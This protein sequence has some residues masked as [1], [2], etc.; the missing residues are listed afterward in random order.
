MAWLSADAVFDPDKLGQLVVGIAAE[1]GHHDSGR[2]QHAMGQLL[3]TQRGCIS[4]T[5]QDRL[6]MLPPG[7]VAWIPPSTPH[8]AEMNE[9][10]GYRSVYLDVLQLG[11]LPAETAVLQ[12]NPLLHAVLE[13]IATAD[14][15]TEWQRGS[16]ANLLAVCLDE[17]RLAHRE[18][19]L[20]RL[21][22]D[23]RLVRLS[24]HVLPASLAALARDVGASEKT[25]SR[26][27]KRQ[28]GLS[29]QQWRQQ[30]RFLKAVE[31][32][33]TKGRLSSVATDLGFASDS[34]FIAFFKQ[35]S[36]LTPREYMPTSAF[37]A[38]NK[39]NET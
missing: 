33:A 3:F 14:F 22:S 32:L 16:A 17:L 29:Y 21:P 20:L 15:A 9:A 24:Y 39:P 27:F 7:R 6:C 35:M 26:I 34:A 36:G 25:I 5:L 31:L 18:P 23:R 4:I 2:H 38:N 11:P 1:L 28:T 37:T 8:R 10:V 30:W 13:R 19:M 12:V